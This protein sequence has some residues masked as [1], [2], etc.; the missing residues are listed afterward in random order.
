MNST[1][2]TISSNILEVEKKAQ[3]IIASD[4][5]ITINN[6][7]SY[8]TVYR[9]S[10]LDNDL[11]VISIELP[12]EI[13]TDELITILNDI[14]SDENLLRKEWNKDKFIKSIT[15]DWE[16]ELYSYDVPINSE[17]GK[18][19]LRLTKLEEYLNYSNEKI[20]S[21]IKI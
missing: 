20:L 6:E 7:Y 15:I 9:R 8:Y 11:K 18:E 13:N 4:I 12:S 21:F 19:V 3:N 2:I 5:I 1:K 14:H 10:F 16:E 17:I